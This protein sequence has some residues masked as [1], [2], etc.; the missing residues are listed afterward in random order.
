MGGRTRRPPAASAPGQG[1]RG[2]DLAHQGHLPRH[3]QL[4]VDL[5]EQ[6]AHVV[7][8]KIRGGCW[9]RPGGAGKPDARTVTARVKRGAC[10][11]EPERPRT[12]KIEGIDKNRA[13]KICRGTAPGTVRRTG[14]ATTKPPAPS[15][16]VGR[17][18]GA[19]AARG[20]DRI[21]SYPRAGLVETAECGRALSVDHGPATTGRSS[22]IHPETPW[23]RPNGTPRADKQ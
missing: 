14:I 20:I 22:A 8:L 1:A 11:P 4:A 13:K 3:A 21:D 2:Q 5:L 18:V 7:L 12:F 16:A 9:A 10:Y 19:S 23:R 6:P 17:C 15:S